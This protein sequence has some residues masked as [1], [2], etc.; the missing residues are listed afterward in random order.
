MT[1][2]SPTAAA[3]SIA[4]VRTDRASRYLQ[5]LAKHFQHKLPVSFDPAAGRISFPIGDCDMEADE[6]ILRLRLT[7]A[8]HTQLAQLQDVVARHLV[9]FAFR[10]DDM[11]I[12]WRP[13]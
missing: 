6:T 10:E 4:E 8:D 9:R 12:E 11:A 5:Q 3:H 13:V 2:L 1:D 7:S